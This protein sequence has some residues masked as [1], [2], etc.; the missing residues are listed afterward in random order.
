MTS[1]IQ[2]I[3]GVTPPEPEA[4]AAPAPLSPGFSLNGGYRQPPP[5]APKTAD[6]IGRDHNALIGDILR[7]AQQGAREEM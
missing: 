3:L 4:P 7:A 6:E 1:L 5:A 2:R